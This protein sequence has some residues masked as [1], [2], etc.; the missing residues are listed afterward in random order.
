MFFRALLGLR[1]ETWFYI[2]A[3]MAVVVC[4]GLFCNSLTVSIGTLAFLTIR[5]GPSK[6]VEKDLSLTLRELE[7]RSSSTLISLPRSER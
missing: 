6:E 1:I 3:N 4:T 2:L 5:R 7:E